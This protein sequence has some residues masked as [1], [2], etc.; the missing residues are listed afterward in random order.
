MAAASWGLI[1]GDLKPGNLMLTESG[2]S[3]AE[4]EVKV[5]DFGLAKATAAIGEADLTNGGF[6]GTPAFAS[7]E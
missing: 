7:P 3:S 2:G 1:H 6:V 4:L 5:I